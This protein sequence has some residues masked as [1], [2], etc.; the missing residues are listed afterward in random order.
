MT[1]PAPLDTLLGTR[2]DSDRER[3]ERKGRAPIQAP[4]PQRHDMGGLTLWDEHARPQRQLFD[5]L[6]GRKR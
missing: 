5:T 6:E 2:H 1:G 4:A 3:A